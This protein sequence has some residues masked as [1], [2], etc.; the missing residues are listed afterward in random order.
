M[1]SVQIHFG[2]VCSV[3]LTIGGLWLVASGLADWGLLAV[4]VMLFIVSGVSWW[5]ERSPALVALPA[6]IANAPRQ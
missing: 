4:G 1:N 2:L 3:L 6:R 5:R